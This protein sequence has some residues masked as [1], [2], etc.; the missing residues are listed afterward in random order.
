MAKRTNAVIVDLD[1]GNVGAADIVCL[2]GE[3]NAE[4]IAGKKAWLKER[5]GEGLKFK[6]LRINGRSWGLIEY[7][8]AENAWRPVEAPG[9]TFIDCL[10]VIGRAQK[11]GYGRRLLDRCAE[12]SKGRS[13]LVTMTSAKSFLARKEFFLANGFELVDTAPPYFELLARRFKK[14]APAPRFKDKAKKS[15]GPDRA[16]LVFYYSD[17]CPYIGPSLKQ[18]TDLAKK[19]R[20][21]FQL[22]KIRNKK[23]AQSCPSAYGTFAVY[24]DGQFLTHQP[25]YGKKL[26][27]LLSS[28]QK[29]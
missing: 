24:L 16:G 2:R 26:D 5:F 7:G 8:P 1:P 9:Y 25:F 20:I 6:V 21:P 11:H 22:V 29:G 18:M 12:D 14:G 19:R 10:W 3:K 28:P 4:G 17:Q 13:G 23:D 15:L 27:K